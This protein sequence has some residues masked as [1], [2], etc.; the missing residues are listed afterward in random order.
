MTMPTKPA[1]IVKTQKTTAL[2]LYREADEHFT[3][4]LTKIS[5]ALSNE[6]K[7]EVVAM[8]FHT[9]NSKWKKLVVDN[10]KAAKGI[11]A[12]Y[13]E[14]KGQ[15]TEN[16]KGKLVDLEFNGRTFRASTVK[17]MSTKPDEAKLIALLEAKKIQLIDACDR[18]ISYEPN[19]EKLAALVKDGKL[20]EAEVLECHKV[21]ATTTK[22]EA[23]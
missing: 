2:S 23:L 7:P 4:A 14:G 12:S 5:Q 11:M 3:E 19:E 18:V 16:G 8:V 22:V 15:P 20:T 13:V 17:S 6:P 9:I 1:A 21:T 10:I